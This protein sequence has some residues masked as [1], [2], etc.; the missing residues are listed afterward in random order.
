[1]SSFIWLVLQVIIYSSLGMLFY[2]LREFFSLI[3]FYLYLGSLELLVSLLNS[4]YVLE[5]TQN[6]VIGGGQVVYTAIIWSIMLI[7]LMERDQKI[8][9]FIIY[10]LV[11]I[12]LMYVVIYPFIYIMLEK[13]L[14]A[15]P[16]SIPPALFKTSWWIFIIGNF[17]RLGE[18]FI[19]I[20]LIEKIQKKAPNFP[21]QVTSLVVFN[22]VLI[23]DGI[24]F[25]LLVFPVISS[26]SLSKGLYGILIKLI[27]GSLFS[28]T[29]ILAMFILRSSFDEKETDEISLLKLLSL[30]KVDLIQ[31]YQI[32]RD[33]QRMNRLLLNLLSH[34]LNNYIINTLGR[35]DMILED[36]G[37]NLS[38]STQNLLKT[39]RRIQYESDFLVNNALN[40]DKIKT[41][42]I[43]LTEVNLQEYVLDSLERIKRMYP[44]IELKVSGVDQ[45]HNVKVVANSLLSNV[46]LNLFINSVKYRKKDQNNVELQFNLNFKV[47]EHVCLCITDNGKGIPDT[48]K[49]NIFEYGNFE[50]KRAKLGL[51]LT[52][53]IL[54]MHEGK[55]EV[56]NRPDSP[57]DYT[58]GT[59]FKIYFRKVGRQ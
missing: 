13:N 14:V 8:V 15:N 2:K 28:I 39:I 16:L 57:D 6:I 53:E 25:P 58:K 27:L 10:C 59:M 30:P 36:D 33:E 46:F 5:I 43:E 47:N 45:L 32:V 29:L 50:K 35:V 44:N 22:F 18:S 12:Q 7:Y 49:P 55:I 34:D 19:M 42:K 24:L 38:K 48:I 4:V 23:I 56:Y 51:Y 40:L 54:K 41:K 37:E 52:S 31:R 3:P 1:M 26:L 17:L 20:Y 9:T 11:I 21:W